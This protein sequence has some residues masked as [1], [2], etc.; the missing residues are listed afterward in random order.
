MFIH[1]HQHASQNCNFH[2]MTLLHSIITQYNK[3]IQ[4]KSKFWDYTVIIHDYKAIVICTNL[5]ANCIIFSL[6]SEKQMALKVS[7]RHTHLYSSYTSCFGR[8]VS[9]CSSRWFRIQLNAY[10]CC[11]RLDDMELWSLQRRKNK[12]SEDRSSMDRTDCLSF[13]RET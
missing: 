9:G 10:I 5:V 13:R 6:A 4:W 7:S 3:V 1:L 8:D 2:W 11:V 12:H